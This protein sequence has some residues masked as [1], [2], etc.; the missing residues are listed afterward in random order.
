MSGRLSGFSDSKRVKRMAPADVKK[1]NR[2]RIMEPVVVLTDNRGSRSA[3]ALGSRR[4][5]GH[6]AS[7]GT[8]QSSN[9]FEC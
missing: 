1:G 5:P 7:V 2:A 8:P 6:V 4:K 9:I 3:F